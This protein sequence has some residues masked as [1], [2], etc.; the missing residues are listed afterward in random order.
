MRH[1]RRLRRELQI[2]RERFPQG[3]RARQRQEE[4]ERHGDPR[5][6]ETFRTIREEPRGTG[7]AGGGALRRVPTYLRHTFVAGITQRNEKGPLP[8][9][10]KA[11]SSS[12]GTKT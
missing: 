3:R 7:R 12:G 5:A 10:A 6:E 1:I 2:R 9:L 4:N 8:E 11:C